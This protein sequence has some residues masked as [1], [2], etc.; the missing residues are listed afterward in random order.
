MQLSE[1]EIGKLDI[2]HSPFRLNVIISDVLNMLTFATSKKVII[3]MASATMIYLRFSLLQGLR[4]IKDTRLGHIEY[5]MG[6]GGRIRQVL[7]NLLTNA[8]KVSILVMYERVILTQRCCAKFTSEGS[9]TL[10]A[11]EESSDEQHVRVRF[12]VKDTGVGIPEAQM[13][14]L[15]RPFSQA[16][17]ST[18]RKFGGTGLGLA[19]SKNVGGS[20]Y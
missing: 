8:I 17:S 3:T 19:I 10:R 2:E 15:F 14:K 11:F 16:D 18:A 4:F 7:T 6:D 1:V 5:V 13:T 20:R 9:I 12:E